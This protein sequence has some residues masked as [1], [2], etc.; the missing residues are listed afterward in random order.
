MEAPLGERTQIHFALAARHAECVWL[1]CKPPTLHNTTLL[2]GEREKAS[3]VHAYTLSE[4]QIKLLPH[5][6]MSNF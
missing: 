2:R 6:I 5:D 1:T 3:S 4:S